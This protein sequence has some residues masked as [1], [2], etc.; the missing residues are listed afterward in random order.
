MAGDSMTWRPRRTETG[1]RPVRAA[2]ARAR[3]RALIAE[4]DDV[5]RRLLVATLKRDRFEVSEA[6]NGRE[7][8]ELVAAAVQRSDARFDLIISDIRMPQMS[9]L[10][11]LA[12]LR[13]ADWACPV[14]LISA[15]AGD[16][17]R[18]EASRLGASA[19]FAKPF[20]LDDL[21][22]AALYLIGA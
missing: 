4:D 21:R 19:F 11:A 18:A 17:T 5:F 14:I 22:T 16:A 2:S 12:G 7:L 15:F 3:P 6:H 8:V 13:A 9:G 10:E 20:D 1:S